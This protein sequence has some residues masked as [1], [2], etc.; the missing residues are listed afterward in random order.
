[1]RAGLERQ[2][3]RVRGVRIPVRGVP[4]RGNVQFAVPSEWHQIGASALAAE[5]KTETGGPGGEWQ[6]AYQASQEPKAT[7]FLSFD[8]AQPFVYA[9]YGTLNGS[10]SRQLSD[11]TLR[12]FFLPVTS[13]ARQN[14]V[15]QGFP[16]TGFRH[17]RDQVLTMSQG[18][19]GV[20][21]TFDYTY[22]RQA[23]TFDED[24]LTNASHTVVF[25]LVVHCTTACY[26]KY[27]DE[28]RHVMS[29]V[30]ISRLG[31]PTGPFTGVVGR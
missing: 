22:T 4:S 17:L 10:A 16:L 26:G 29:S 19:H 15:A 27:Q 12:D 18:T 11:Q 25:L 14:A 20:R 31:Q 23:D 6:V 28:I 21:E 7:G 3:F 1:M 2:P 8:I 24:T 13:A 30:A 5:L 9:E